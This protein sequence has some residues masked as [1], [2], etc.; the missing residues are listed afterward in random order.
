MTRISRYNHF[1]PWR[2]GYRLAYNARSGALGLMTDD[3]FAVYQALMTKFDA[4]V[5][6]PLTEAE[7]TLLKQLEYGRFA[8]SEPRDEYQTLKFE[9]GLSRYDQTEMGLVVAPTL[10]CNM[11]CQY[12]YEANKKGKMSPE[13]IEAL[14]A[15]VESK[16]AALKH[17]D[18]C[19]Y[20]GEPLLAM[21]VIEDISLTMID[22]GKAKDFQYTATMISNGYLLTKDVVDKLM[23]LQVKM[24]QVT[25]DGPARMHDEKRPLKNGKDSF[26]KIVENIKYACTKI[27]VGV[28]VNVDK[29]YD[30][31]LIEELLLELKAAGLEKRIGLYFGQLEAASTACANIHDTCYNTADFSGVEIEYFTLLLRHGFRIEKLPQPTSAFCMAQRV[32]AFVIDHEGEMYRCYNYVGDHDKSM[33]NIRDSVNYSH[34]NF[35]RLFDFNAFEDAKCS[36]CD[37]LPICLGGCPAHRADRGF[38]PDEMCLGWRHNLKPML[39]IIAASRQQAASNSSPKEARV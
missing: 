12:C 23:D 3:N 14:I 21:D 33:G 32:Y 18:I 2:D 20:G 10:A 8:Y 7:Q 9:H 35:T 29:S 27:M 17:V 39:E 38:A 34:P 22:M 11:A 24:I 36:S 16:S 6:S 31:G 5:G 28:R 30:L 19:W 13:T 25:L 4:A 37:I 26:A 1:H 15:F